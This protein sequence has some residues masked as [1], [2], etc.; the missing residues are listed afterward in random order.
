MSRRRTH[1]AT[2]QTYARIAATDG[3]EEGEHEKEDAANSRLMGPV[4]YVQSRPGAHEDVDHVN[5][6]IG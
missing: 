6:D 3:E 5:Y 4:H 2:S 1:G